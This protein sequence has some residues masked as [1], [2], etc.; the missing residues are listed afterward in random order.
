M[1]CHFKLLYFLFHLKAFLL[2]TGFS[3]FLTRIRLRNVLT[4]DNRGNLMD[5]MVYIHDVGEIKKSH[6][7]NKG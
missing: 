6:N 1:S 5:L 7:Q 3:P 4:R 2:I